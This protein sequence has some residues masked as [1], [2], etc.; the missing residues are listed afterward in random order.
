MLDLIVAL[1]YSMM[2]MF[3]AYI[4][5]LIGSILIGTIMAR[6]RHVETFL[7]PILDILQSIP[8]LGFFP[9]VLLLFIRAI[10]NKLG[11]ELAIIFL[12]VTS[13]IWNMI[14]GVY[15]SI[16]S[17]DPAIYDLVKVYRL[18]VVTTFS[19]IY[20]PA[21]IRAIAA[22]SII[23]WAGGWFFI[24]S[25]E[26][27]TIGVSEI[28][29]SGIGTYIMDSFSQG[30]MKETYLG[31]GVL[32]LSV[33]ATYIFLWNPLFEEVGGIKLL[34]YNK[35]YKYIIKK[36]VMYVYDNVITLIEILGNLLKRF[37]SKCS[38]AT[39]K[40]IRVIMATIALIIFLLLLAI[41]DNYLKEYWWSIGLRVSIS[42][43]PAQLSLNLLLSLSRVLGVV[44]LSVLISLFLSYISY[45]S[46]KSGRSIFIHVVLIGETLASIPAIFWW[47]LLF[48]LVK[49][50]SFG[51]YAVSLIVFLQG[52]LWYSFFN[53]MLFGISNVRKDIVDLADI[54]RIRGFYFI[55]HIFIPLLLPSIATSALSSWG[56]AWN[57]TIVA[58][59]FSAEN[60]TINL[61]GVGAL[62]NIALSNGDTTTLL[63]LVLVLSLLI[64]TINKTLWARFF[65]KL[66][67][68]FAVE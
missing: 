66:S 68:R 15:S 23:S 43:D 12:I 65:K 30:N 33:I 41:M 63:I 18:G 5:S 56:G 61:G 40:L 3:V 52:S 8:I 16:K 53:I 64:T 27:L 34:S 49:L 44:L 13:M 45:Y 47:P 48:S 22:N 50:R 37:V 26:V 24:T 2:R 19:R 55:K 28:K 39:T 17:L 60:I 54:Y 11:V 62:M 9:M 35:V 58:E 31:I 42:V 59:Y 21:S 38:F 29:V 25:S 1:I 36:I 57:S 67:G 6:N 32:I 20:V 14:F 51:A 46:I 4:L 10:P 7:L